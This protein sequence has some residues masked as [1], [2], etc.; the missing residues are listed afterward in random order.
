MP[1]IP[2]Y[3]QGQ[4]S[5]VRTA[6]GSLSPRANVGAFTAAGQAQAAFFEKAADVAYQF[7]MAEK[8]AETDKA[9]RDIQIQ[10]NQEMNEFTRNN[11]DTTVSGYQASAQVKREQ[12]RAAS[13]ERLRGSLTNRQFR[14][15]SGVFDSTFATKL[16]QG[17]SV[18]FAKHNVI[19]TNSA[20]TYL[21]EAYS[22]MMSLD[23]NSEM[24]K[25]Q[26]Q[27]ITNQFNSYIAQGISPSKYKNAAAFRKAV[28]A[29]SFTRRVEGATTQEEIER[30]RSET[31]PRNDLDP[32]VFGARISALDS[33]EKVIQAEITEAVF[34][35]L[36]LIS[37]ENL[38]DYKNL[39]ETIERIRT[40]QNFDV[41]D[42]EGNYIEVKISELKSGS[43]DLLIS[44]LK[45]RYDNIN[46][47]NQNARLTQLDTQL[48]AEDASLSDVMR[49]EDQLN[50]RDG[51]FS[52][53]TD[54]GEI[55]AARRK[56]DSAKSSIA[57]KAVSQALQDQEDL[58]ASISAANGEVSEEM[59]AETAR[60][61][62]TL[63]MAEQFTAAHELREA[64]IVERDASQAFEKT[65]FG[66][67]DQRKAKLDELSQPD[68]INTDVGRKTLRAYNEK[69]QLA[70]KAMSEDFVGY[71]ETKRGVELTPSQAITLQRNMGIAESDIR[72]TSNRKIEAFQA[73]FK[74][75][76]ATYAEKGQIAQEFIGQ[77]GV[78]G[79]RVMRQLM[80]SGAI[81]TADNLIM[82][83]PGDVSMKA[84]SIFNEESMTSRYKSELNK[85]VRT[86]ISTQVTERIGD[87]GKSILGGVSDQILGGGV[88][89]ARTNHVMAMRDI[90][91][92]TAQGYLLTGQVGGMDDVQD[93]VDLAYKNVIGKHF[94]FHEING[95]PLRI[96]SGKYASGE[97]MANVLQNSITMNEAKLRSVVDTPPPPIGTTN[98]EDW[99]NQYFSDLLQ[100]GTWRT[101]TD[102]QSAYL[103]DQLGNIVVQKGKQGRDAYITVSLTDIAEY[104]KTYSEVQATNYQGEFSGGTKSDRLKRYMDSIL[105]DIF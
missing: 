19:R 49:L 2:L 18:A 30:L 48:Y 56:I 50:N 100:R 69:L 75:P 97:G 40:G 99:E 74:N 9:K 43:I 102:N 25:Q 96:D 32:S 24:Y 5:Q 78:H 4:G 98:P 13:L 71:Y 61:A 60:I 89:G 33:Q 68:K 88:T 47:K 86:E 21:D 105:A 11:E 37:D 29:G 87:Y 101:T 23:P 15:V 53:M 80:A 81:N 10:I 36:S 95:T 54:S 3:N 6:T 17:T 76:E 39:E 65:L 103:V 85:D 72:V 70:Q 63:E 82:A 8:Q 22:N 59:E 28:D 34:K 83:Y 94:E 62:N 7:G 93:A 55:D 38:G 12:M 66:T 14:E 27:E 44:K 16:A 26:D 41:K 84:I 77:F 79:N 92:N 52:G 64:V 51:I 31:K 20:D 57:K 91:I 1:K 73:A 90:I 67:A 46:S 35:E 104:G 45:A 58:I 42:D